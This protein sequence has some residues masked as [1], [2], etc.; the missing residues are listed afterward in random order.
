M[1]GWHSGW[2]SI[3]LKSRPYDSHSHSSVRGR[4]KCAA[5]ALGRVCS[6]SF[7]MGQAS[8]LAHQSAMYSSSGCLMGTLLMNSLL[9]ACVTLLSSTNPPPL[10]RHVSPVVRGSTSWV[11]RRASAHQVRSCHCRPCSDATRCS[12]WL[13]PMPT[14]TTRTQR[15]SQ[16]CTAASTG[17]QTA[18][19]QKATPRLPHSRFVCMLCCKYSTPQHV[20]LAGNGMD[21]GWEWWALPPS[22]GGGQRDAITSTLGLASTLCRRVA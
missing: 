17:R 11:A 7:Q 10:H 4:V 5:A 3:T 2:Y 1:A 13:T 12:V 16:G 14:S 21:L 20:L 22:R 8:G 19:W 9:Q 15:V 6:V 18:R